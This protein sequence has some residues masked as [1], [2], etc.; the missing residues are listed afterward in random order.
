MI[1][2]VPRFRTFVS[3]CSCLLLSS[4]NAWVPEGWIDMQKGISTTDQNLDAG[5]CYFMHTCDRILF[6]SSR[7]D[8]S[9]HGVHA[10]DGPVTKLVRCHQFTIRKGKH[11]KKSIRLLILIKRSPG[12]TSQHP[13][14]CILYTN[15]A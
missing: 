3:S 13:V 11:F 8:L 4:A 15:P 6:A 7:L 5:G 12:S 14:Q 9:S 1:I 10:S 2:V